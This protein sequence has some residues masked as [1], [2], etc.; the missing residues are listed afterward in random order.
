MAI[1]FE[2]DAFVESYSFDSK[3]KK[4]EEGV[5]IPG[6][7]NITGIEIRLARAHV[8]NN[9]VASVKPFFKGFAQLYVI[10]FVVSDVGN[11]LHNIDVK[12]FHKVGDGE[13]LPI[14]K[15]LYYWKQLK[16]D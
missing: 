15:T 11:M 9:R 1:Q 4:T 5:G 10:E 2:N 14:E 12:A 6:S 3:T 16:D 13:D 8:I 7:A